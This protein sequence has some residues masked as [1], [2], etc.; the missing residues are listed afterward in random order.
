MALPRLKSIFEDLRPTADT[1]V[2]PA[3]IEYDMMPGSSCLGIKFHEPWNKGSYTVLYKGLGDATNDRVIQACVDINEEMHDWMRH[4]S[5]RTGDRNFRT[6]KYKRWFYNQGEWRID[7]KKLF[8][9]KNV[10]VPEFKAEVTD[11]ATGKVY[12]I[13]GEIHEHKIRKGDSMSAREEEL[14]MK[15]WF[16]LHVYVNNTEVSP[17]YVQDWNYYADVDDFPECLSGLQ[18]TPG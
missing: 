4:E 18:G 15:V 12:Q 10:T 5:R 1:G 3:K 7:S 13:R 8:N 9:N 17:I 16:M 6:Q 2:T 14:G 11:P